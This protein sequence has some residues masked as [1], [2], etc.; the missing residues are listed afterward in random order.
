V[1][2]A[3][4]IE[5]IE[6]VVRLAQEARTPFYRG[7]S[8]SYEDELTPAVFR[9]KMEKFREEEFRQF[10]PN[11]ERFFFIEFQRLAP[12]LQKDLPESHNYLSWLFLM[13]HHCGAQK[14]LGQ[15]KLAMFAKSPFG[16]G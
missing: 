5:N 14:H 16:E 4:T 9:K 2:S 3:G 10:Q 8:R 12:I 11:Y 6:Q 15:P 7:H 13:Q 1:E